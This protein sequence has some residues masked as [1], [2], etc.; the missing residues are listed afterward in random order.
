MSETEGKKIKGDIKILLNLNEEQKEAKRLIYN[1]PITLIEGQAG[2]G[3]THVA[4][5][6]ALEMLFK[7]QVEQII[8]A[9]PFVM[10][11]EDIG[12]LPGGVDQKLE[13]LISP[14]YNLVNDLLKNKEQLTKLLG[15]DKIKV[16]P[17]GFLRGHTF[18]N[19][20]IIID[21]AQ[22]CSK[23]QTELI[24]GRLGHDSKL[25]FCGDKSQCDLKN[26]LDSGINLLQDL[27][28]NIEEVKSIRLN[29]NYRHP[30]VS[31]IIDYV[32]E[33]KL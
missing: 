30:V 9:R 16:I 28:K 6:A 21:E 5:N 23:I 26:K 7:K 24:L 12:F 22:N 11:G 31:K 18:S 29:Q 32:T 4:V 1:Y 25:V 10:A 14:I 2:T 19:K 20:A 13:Y 8:V 15:D 27:S 3:K 17:I 33:N